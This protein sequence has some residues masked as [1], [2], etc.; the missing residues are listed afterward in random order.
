MAHVVVFTSVVDDVG[1]I[2]PLLGDAHGVQRGADAAAA[3]A[4]AEGVGR[5]QTHSREDKYY[6]P[7]TTG[8]AGAGCILRNECWLV[9]I[10]ITRTTDHVADATA[11]Q[12]V[13]GQ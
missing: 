10:S 6:L 5:T 3:S 7:L 11:G 12:C 4:V 8:G 13:A 9:A 2:T 1:N